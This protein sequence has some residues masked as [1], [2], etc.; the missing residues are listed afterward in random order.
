ML[1]R[2]D[3]EVTRKMILAISLIKVVPDQEKAVYYALKDIDGIRS[4]YHL[5]GDHDFLLILEAEDSSD[6]NQTLDKII[7]VNSVSAMQTML[8]GSSRG[9]QRHVNEICGEACRIDGG[10]ELCLNAFP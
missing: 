8:A 2:L 4:M 1:I 7:E 10:K 6:L 9:F 3:W 5:F